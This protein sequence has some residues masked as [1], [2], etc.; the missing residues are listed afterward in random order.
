M[1]LSAF[2]AN[3]IGTQETLAQARNPILSMPDPPK[4]LVTTKNISDLF[5]DLFPGMPETDILQCIGHAFKEVIIAALQS[6]YKFTHISLG[7]WS[8]RRKW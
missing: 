7:K 3:G 4:Q 5:K 8:G 1:V 2:R 6:W